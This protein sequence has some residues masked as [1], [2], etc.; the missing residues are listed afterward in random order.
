MNQRL[1]QQEVNFCKQ[2]KE[3]HGGARVTRGMGAK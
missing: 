2:Q 3:N 1:N